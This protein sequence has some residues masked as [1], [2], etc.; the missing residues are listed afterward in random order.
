MGLAGD[1]G[2][3]VA[4]GLIGISRSSGSVRALGEDRELDSL[5][6]VAVSR[7]ARRGTVLGPAEPTDICRVDAIVEVVLIGSGT[8]ELGLNCLDNLALSG[9]AGGLAIVN[10]ILPGPVDGGAV[11]HSSVA[12]PIEHG[13]LESLKVEALAS[14]ARNLAVVYGAFPP[15]IFNM[16]LNANQSA[17]ASGAILLE[18]VL[19]GNASSVRHTKLLTE[20]IV[21]ELGGVTRIGDESVLNNQARNA[22]E[23]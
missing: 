6:A 19:A 20:G 23:P 21:G 15:Q 5:N 18:S 14:G 4:L 1:A 10:P 2:G 22:I 13:E 11:R 16:R 12:R 7:C 8:R 9:C 3:H 17:T